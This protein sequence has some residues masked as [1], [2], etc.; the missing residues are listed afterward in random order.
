MQKYWNNFH[1]EG[2]VGVAWLERK[3]HL[4]G[5]HQQFLVH[6]GVGYTVGKFD[7]SLA[8]THYSNAEWAFDWDGSNF[9]YGFLT[10]QIGYV[11]K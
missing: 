2:S 4:S 3:T 5:A 7:F 8:Q 9:G 10:F 6:I 11:L 1:L